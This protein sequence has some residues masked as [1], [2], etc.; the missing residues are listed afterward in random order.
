MAGAR[1]LGRRILPGAA[2]LLA[3]LLLGGPLRAEPTIPTDDALVLQRV[4][5]SSD[6]R[7]KAIRE[8]SAE[9]SL[10]PGDPARS[11]D[12]ATRQLKLGVAESDPRFVGYAQ[13]TL[14]PWWQTPAPPMPIRLVRARILQA[15]HDFA[16]ARRDLQAV[17]AADPDQVEAHLVLAGVSETTGDLTLA[18]RECDEVARRRPTL[19]AT[20]CAASV[21]S[22]TGHADHAYVLLTLATLRARSQDPALQCWALTILAEIESRRDDP[23]ADAHFREALAESPDDVYTLT[24]YA[25]YLLAHHRP[26]DVARLLA[27]R[28]RID[29]LLLRLALAARDSHDP[30][31]GA[32]VDE[33]AA[34]Y[35]AAR[36]RGGALHQR[37][38]SR[39][40]LELRGNPVRALELAR[41]NW[42]AQRTP[43]DA[44]TYLSASLAAKDMDGVRIVADW[45][46]ATGLQDRRLQHMLGLAG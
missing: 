25:D 10:H 24:D 22:L 31:L 23:G 27:G 35:D 1:S 2:A 21:E 3:P 12:L 29:A 36:A 17:L 20:A 19:A 39:F 42:A 8:L 26:A 7:L 41:Q 9:L 30:K 44:L 15:Q 14:T 18:R 5:P 37:D 33:L 38:E 16:A 34:R 6:P 32:Y 40:Q 46:R 28:E 4:M 43:I 45:V 11:L 13:G